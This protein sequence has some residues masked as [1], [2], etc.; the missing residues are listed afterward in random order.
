MSG[1]GDIDEASYTGISMGVRASCVGGEP[2]DGCAGEDSMPVR[3]EF[4]CAL[5]CWPPRTLTTIWRRPGTMA[6][7][8]KYLK[9][10]IRL[11]VLKLKPE[12]LLGGFS[13]LGEGLRMLVSELC[14]TVE[15]VWGR[16]GRVSCGSMG[17]SYRRGGML[18]EALL[19]LL[20][21]F[22]TSFCASPVPGSSP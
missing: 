12:P 11:R 15:M 19:S 10:G 8:P 22:G 17:G 13:C 4:V 3:S 14:D 21:A 7:G 16:C 9:Y 2:T 6:V 20:A 5:P 1:L 18:F